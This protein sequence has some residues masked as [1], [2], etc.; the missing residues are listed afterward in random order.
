MPPTPLGGGGEALE[1]INEYVDLAARFGGA[2]KCRDPRGLRR[3]LRHH[4]LNADHRAELVEWR[5]MAADV[6]AAA[7]RAA[8]T[9]AESLEARYQAA[10][11]MLQDQRWVAAREQLRG[12]LQPGEWDLWIAAMVCPPLA[13]GME[14]I[15]LVGADRYHTAI[16]ADRYG[17]AI[18]EA[19][20]AAGWTGSIKYAGPDS[21]PIVAD[22]QAGTST[23][24]L[25]FNLPPP[26]L[27][28][29]P[30]LNNSE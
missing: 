19:L 13:P 8:A 18:R 29:S 11:E 1:E 25:S 21:L 15:T 16:V 26:T 27:P 22:H 17:Q 3:Y 9:T 5:L 6:R 28:I 2:D 7:E 20:V 12:R 23:T 4:G 14:E 30:A 10:Q 24:V